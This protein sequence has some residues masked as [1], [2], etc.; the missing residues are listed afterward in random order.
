MFKNLRNKLLL[1]HL[2]ITAALIT[3]SFTVI[4]LMTR[5]NVLNGIDMALNGAM[6]ILT[7]KPHANIDPP[8]LDADSTPP[9]I[10]TGSPDAVSPDA[11]PP[12]NTAPGRQNDRR[13]DGPF[14]SILKYTIDSEGNITD[15]NTAIRIT[16]ETVLA[17]LNQVIPGI[18]AEGKEKGHI[19]VGDMSL[20]YKVRPITNGHAIV[21][22]EFNAERGI[23]KRLFLILILVELGALGLTFFVSLISANSAIRPIEESYN[24]QKQFI[25]DASH[26]LKTPLTTINTNIDVLLSHEDS[27]IRDE[28]KWLLYIQSEAQ[29]MAKL[30]NDLLYLARL[31]HGE[32]VIYGETSFSDAAESVTLAMEAVAFERGIVIDE[33]I[34][35]QVLVAASPDQLKQ[36][37]MILMDN[38]IKYTPDGGRIRISLTGG[39]EA[40][41]KVRNSGSGIDKEDMK[42]LFE[43]FYRSDKSRARE[44]G[45][46]GLGL[47][48]AKAI[49]ESFGGEIEVASKID[50]YTEFTVVL[51]GIENR[52]A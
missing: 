32:P 24:K 22:G 13:G 17:Q 11:V 46:Y 45:G 34:E 47:A 6:S 50:E 44:S 18:V 41:L 14:S 43:R 35:E 49:T 20:E 4:F 19:S 2:L 10:P 28:K 8:R 25:A 33:A 38:A 9:P 29:R 12:D 5:Q 51:L 23:L 37:V 30:T 31:D 15:R 39:K 21:L 36:L 1:V 52:K 3:G 42:Q 48:I 16:D 26:E 7:D 40:T 27:L